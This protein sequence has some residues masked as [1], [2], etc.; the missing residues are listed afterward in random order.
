MFHLW[1]IG[2]L[3][4]VFFLINFAFSAMTGTF[5][6]WTE[7]SFQ[8]GPSEIGWLYAFV[9]VVAIMTQL[10]LLPRL[11]SRFGERKLLKIGIFALGVGLFLIVVAHT[12][13]LIYPALLFI[14]F[15]NGI[16]NPTIQALASESVVKEEYG[17]TLGLLQSAGSLGRIIGPVSGGELFLKFGKNTPFLFSALLMWG[18]FLILIRWLSEIYQVNA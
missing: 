4:V 11:V 17:G 12:P 14:A 7:N 16:A 5:A 1:D 2:L 6:L 18:V 10:W 8:Y 13:A 3:I 9:G 15:G